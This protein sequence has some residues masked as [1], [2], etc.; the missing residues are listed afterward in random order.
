MPSQYRI[1]FIVAWALVALQF[2]QAYLRGF[3][4]HPL[5]ALG[6]PLVVTPFAF[7]HGALRYGWRKMFILFIMVFGTGFTFETMSVLTGFPFGH[8]HYTELLGWQLGVV[9]VSVMPSYFAFGYISWVLAGI[10]LQ[11]FDNR[12]IGGEILIVPIIAAYIMSAWDLRIDPLASTINPMWVWEEGGTYFGVPIS[13]FLGWYFVVL[14]FYLMFALLNRSSND[15]PTPDIV[16][17]KSY[18]LMAILVYGSQLLDNLTGYMWRENY[19]VTSLDGHDWW[20]TDIYGA[21]LVVAL[22]TVLPITAYSW[23]QLNKAFAPSPAQ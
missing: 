10:I 4:D 18:W 15:Q 20:A 9:P 6:Y 23:L 19:M 5:L 17:I 8:Y 22:W 3:I 2:T 14:I 21:M 7:W 13:N 11:R 1:F 16:N 12:I